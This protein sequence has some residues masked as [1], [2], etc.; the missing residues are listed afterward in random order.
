ML[1]VI[2]GLSLIGI[3]VYS[4]TDLFRPDPDTARRESFIES[5]QGI[6]PSVKDAIRQGEVLPGMSR[7]QVAASVGMA[8]QSAQRNGTE[9]LI[10]PTAEATESTSE[11]A[12]VLDQGVVA[13]VYPVSDDERI[14]DLMKRVLYIHSHEL[15]PEREQALANR[16][17]VVGMTKQE[18]KLVKPKVEVT[19]RPESAHVI[20]GDGWTLW[21]LGVVV[22]HFA[23]DHLKEIRQPSG[24]KSSQ[25]LMRKWA[26]LLNHPERPSEVAAGLFA[27][28]VVPG[29]KAAEVSLAWGKPSQAIQVGQA[30]K[31]WG[32]L[33]KRQVL[34]FEEDTLT[35]MRSV[36]VTSNLQPLMTRWT[37]TL[38]ADGLSSDVKTAL[39]NKRVLLGMTREEVTLVHGD[40]PLVRQ[41]GEN[42]EV[43]AYPDGNVVMRFEGGRLVE[44]KSPQETSV[45]DLFARWVYVLEHPDRDA[46]IREAILRRRLKAGLQGHEVSLIYGDPTAK[47]VIPEDRELWGYRSIVKVL[48]FDNDTLREFRNVQS[49]STITDV[50]RRWTYVLTTEVSE[51]S[52]QVIMDG[53]IDIGLSTREVRASWGEPV[54]TTVQ[55]S[56]G[57]TVE[58][59]VYNRLEGQ[60]ELT[61]Q[62][63]ELTNW[64]AF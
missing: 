60:Y 14:E 20:I 3:I 51:E 55:R 37:Y 50:F 42:Q 47:R 44:Q 54:D 26:Y 39:L 32:Y 27:S 34:L 38:E 61:F 7:E 41:I 25:R 5:H 15:P 52:R 18:V 24:S 9:V 6:S 33:G 22:L 1:L 35:E 13:K 46:A 40:P 28:N 16:E 56:E 63:D 10:V 43:I 45:R 30:R 58:T 62:N 12:I 29:M 17:I 19:M 23:Q 31:L 36:E 64:T 49:D 8:L 57:E 2:I 59:W 48:L 21:D 53:E 11:R 4:G